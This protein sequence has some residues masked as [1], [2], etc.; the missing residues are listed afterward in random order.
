[1]TL[2]VERPALVPVDSLL[3]LYLQQNIRDF[4]LLCEVRLNGQPETFKEL[5]EHFKK[6]HGEFDAYM[7][8][9]I[10]DGAFVRLGRATSVGARIPRDYREE[11]FTL[12]LYGLSLQYCNL[13][14]HSK[15]L[16]EARS[17]LEFL[18]G[19]PDS[20]FGLLELCYPGSSEN[21]DRTPLF[22]LTDP[23]LEKFILQNSKRKNVFVSIAFTFI[24]CGM[25]ATSGKR[26]NL[27]FHNCRFDEGAA[28]LEAL[29]ARQGEELGS[30]HLT[31]RERLP[32]DEGNLVASMDRLE[33]ESLELSLI[34][35][36]SE[37]CC[38]AVA[39][40]ELQYLNLDECELRGDGGAA[41]VAS[42]REGRGP[43]GLC[44]SE[45]SAP[46][47]IVNFLHALGGNTHIERLDLECLDFRGGMWQ[48]FTTGLGG[49][50][51]LKHLGVNQIEG[52]DDSLF[53]SLMGAIS[54]HPSLC[55]QRFGYIESGLP[56]FAE[57]VS[58]MLSINKQVEEISLED[59]K[60]DPDVWH[61]FVAPKLEC[62]VY[63][64]RFAAMLNIADESVRAAVVARALAR[65]KSKPS[66]LY[67][68]LTCNRDILSIYLSDPPST[69][70]SDLI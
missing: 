43:K 25:L 15:T 14:I 28:F 53:S 2:E 56:A 52:L 68:L 38:R 39:T 31:F 54:Q 67:M 44:L 35:L 13:K 66:L 30:A 24:Q 60:F 5:V 11:R 62:N 55:T 36:S 9:W 33:L 29:V 57:S 12:C 22:P 3:R 10:T 19:L 51:G 42:V 58:E 8:I 46:E 69:M 37:E 45:V 4:H 18:F 23:L 16:D 61:E 70:A 32:F 6:D 63:R 48:A 59:D 20:Q 1:V 64:K 65:V 40:A 26:T 27:G 7:I 41:L 21:E 50:L 34:N 47:M 49:N 17:C